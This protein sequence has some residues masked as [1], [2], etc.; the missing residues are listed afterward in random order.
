MFKE[1]AQSAKQREELLMMKTSLDG[2]R[3]NDENDTLELDRERHPVGRKDKE[4]EEFRRCG[5]EFKNGDETAQFKIAHSILNILTSACRQ[6][7]VDT[8]HTLDWVCLL[9]GG[10]L[11]LIELEGVLSSGI[12]EQLCTQI[13]TDSGEGDHL[14][15]LHVLDR[16]CS[17]LSEVIEN[18]K[19]T[20]TVQKNEE[21]KE[22]QFS[23]TRRCGFAIAR[24]EKAVLVVEK[25]VGGQRNADRKTREVQEKIGGM[26]VRHFRSS[27]HSLE[28]EIG[29]IGIDLVAV[30]REM[31]DKMRQMEA[32]R[33]KL[34]EEVEKEK[35]EIEMR[36]NERKL[37]EKSA[38]EE[39]QKEFSM[40]MREIEEMKKM[41]EKWIEEGRQ[42]DEEKKREAERKRI[43]EE[44]EERRKMR[45]EGAAA[46]EVFQPL[47][48][49][50]SGNVF[51]KSVTDCS[52]IFTITFGP[53]VVRFTFVIRQCDPRHL[54]VGLIAPEMVEQATPG[55]GYFA[56][57]KRAANWD[58]NPS[59]KRARQN[60]KDS[61][62]GSICKDAEVGQ[63]VV[64]EADGREGKRTLKLSQDGE[65]Q[66]TFFSNIP[67][68]FRFGIFLY[69]TG[70]SVEIVSTEVLR[71]ASMV[72]G[73]LDVMMD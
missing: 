37:A 25:R 71:E 38:E 60:N 4:M 66:P 3:K 49:T 44:D 35:R 39:R 47:K 15:A 36:D 65:T 27:I 48:F 70:A 28:K 51:T 6:F 34:R 17:G 8:S 32:E 59:Y 1:T 19:L 21:A 69:T 29:E 40:K 56:N 14:P 12:V 46:I 9:F 30:R 33:T 42:R 43:E 53:I 31:D 58:L 52:S 5:S 67:V 41:N 57:L 26:I 55:R 7:V 13:E 18:H 68:P 2:M 11:S 62:H 61:P 64:L 23:L 22:D 20:M 63:R 45:K 24:I 50:L 16:L 72:G 73:S 54:A 10:S